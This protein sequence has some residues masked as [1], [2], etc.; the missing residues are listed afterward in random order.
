MKRTTTIA[1]VVVAVAIILVGSYAVYANFAQGT[2]QIEL[3]DLPQSWGNVTQIY[4][5]YSAIEIHRADAENS[6]SWTTTADQGWINLTTI[7]DVNQTIGSKSLQPGTY[8]LIRFKINQALVTVANLNYSA[9]VPSGTLQIAI[10]QSGI[11]VKAGQTSTL[12]ID[13]S[14]AVHGSV[15]TGFTIVPDVR[16]TPE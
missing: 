12:L 9:N 16:A 3:T 13:L 14:I 5:N 7:L 10:T 2:L 1:I 8:N 4:L 15:D 11:T 6:S